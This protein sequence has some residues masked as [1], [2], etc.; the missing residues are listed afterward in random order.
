MKSFQ[1]TSTFVSTT[2]SSAARKEIS[3]RPL[4]SS[5]Q[6][7]PISAG[8]KNFSTKISTSPTFAFG[9]DSQLS[10][11]PS[12]SRCVSSRNISLSL[13]LNSKLYALQRRN[14]SKANFSC[15]GASKNLTAAIRSQLRFAN[16]NQ[17]SSFST[18]RNYLDQQKVDQPW[19]FYHFDFDFDYFGFDVFFFHFNP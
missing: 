11:A 13:S 19:F 5:L 1:S 15:L 18:T 2:A 8:K 16:K 3:F 12:S 6:S 10:P 7:M 9:T 14:F 17:I 4:I